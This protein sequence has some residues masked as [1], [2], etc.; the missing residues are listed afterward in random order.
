MK[1]SKAFLTRGFLNRYY[2]GMPWLERILKDLSEGIYRLGLWLRKGK[3]SF[4]YAYPHF[5]SRGATLYKIARH[6]DLAITNRPPSRPVALVHWEYLTF[7]EEFADLAR[8]APLQDVINGK[9]KDISKERV[10][11]IHQEIFGY[12]TRIDPVRYQGKAV[13]KSDINALHNYAV[14]DCPIAER[15]EGAFYQILINNEVHEGTRVEDIRVPII[16]GTLPFAYL[17]HRD[18]KVRFKNPIYCKPL[19][20]EELLSAEEITLI[21]A[22]AKRFGLDFGEM[23]VLRNRDDGRIYIIDVNTTSQGPPSGISEADS[24]WAIDQMAQA[25]SQRCLS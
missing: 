11:R 16:K 1:R 2:R 6:L 13:Q 3:V 17:K 5:P 9:V 19:P 21:N 25:F 24:D 10:D 8:Y 22:Y 20:I 15:Q 4:I 18:I 7:Q 23:D 14:L 12:A